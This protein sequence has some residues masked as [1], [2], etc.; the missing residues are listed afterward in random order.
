MNSGIR[1]GS[2]F[3]LKWG[4]VDFVAKTVTLR[5]STTKSGKLLRL[6]MNKTFINTLAIWRKQST[7]ITPEALI[8]PSP[9]KK[10]T[11]MVD[12]K[13]SWET[14]LKFAQIENFRFHD[15]RHNFASQLVM[16]GVDLNVIRELLGH[17]DMKMTLRYAHLAP[18]SKLRAVELLDA[19]K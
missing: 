18:E 1:R 17:A 2:L 9:K 16:Q 11:L 14:V 15:L 13:R 10:G 6:P 5:A 7:D 12:I 19:G 3:S 8:F 4:D